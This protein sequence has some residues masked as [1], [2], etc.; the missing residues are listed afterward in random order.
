MIAVD[1]HVGVVYLNI[2]TPRDFIVA[3]R[4][5]ACDKGRGMA[6][7]QGHETRA[8]A[9][10][11][12]RGMAQ[13]KGHA[14]REGACHKGTG[15]PQQREPTTAGPYP[16]TLSVTFPRGRKPERLETHDFRRSIDSF[17]TRAAFK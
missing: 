5:A 4:A 3:T 17:H 13:G 8:G 16:R 9:W 11:K 6:Q 7:G 1:D 15:M 14:T 2:E 12:G 10:H